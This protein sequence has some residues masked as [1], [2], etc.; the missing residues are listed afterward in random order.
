MS[1]DNSFAYLSSDI[2][3]DVIHQHF[4]ETASLQAF[5]CLS[6]IEGPW[7]DIPHSLK[8]YEWS[9]GSLFSNRLKNGKIVDQQIE[10]SKIPEIPVIHDAMMSYSED[11]EI[12]EA[13]APKISHG[14]YVSNFNDKYFHLLS[15]IPSTL[16][17][18]HLNWLLADYTDRALKLMDIEERETV[19]D[20]VTR[21]LRTPYLRELILSCKLDLPKALKTSLLDFIDRP[22]FNELNLKEA[23]SSFFEEV[24]VRWRKRMSFPMEDDDPMFAPCVKFELSDIER[25]PELLKKYGFEESEIDLRTV[26]SNG[27]LA[28]VYKST[29]KHPLI[30]EQILRMQIDTSDE[31]YH[32]VLIEFCR[33][34]RPQKPPIP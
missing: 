5:L 3:Y 30:G 19:V 22:F 11:T 14:L 29:E 6:Q 27:L 25:V 18:V 1:V 10:D 17:E 32:S 2:I 21:Q 20:F 13:I 24:I 23:P 16:H 4:E 15:Q 8:H 34:T 7:G 26:L 12:I 31:R 33:S 9:E 28:K